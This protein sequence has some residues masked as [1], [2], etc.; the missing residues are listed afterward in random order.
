VAAL[1]HWRCPS[2]WSIVAPFE[3]SLCSCYVSPP[4]GIYYCE[5]RLSVAPRLVLPE[6]AAEACVIN[7][8]ILGRRGWQT[9]TGTLRWA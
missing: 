2:R 8:V 9:V 1:E 5:Y 6:H 7:T 4:L 3:H